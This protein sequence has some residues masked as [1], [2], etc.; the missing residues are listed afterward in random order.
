[1]AQTYLLEGAQGE[2]H[3]IAT[4][5]ASGAGTVDLDLADGNVHHVTLTGNP[6][7][8]FTTALTG[9]ALRFRLYL[10]QDGT[11]S[12]TVTWPGTVDWPGGTAPTLTT[13]ADGVDVIDFETV[14]DGTTWRGVV[15]GQ[16][17]A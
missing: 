1:M 16:A 14:D 13:T 11:G 3:T 10:V 8:T 12:R 4:V 2:R 7:F 9:V 6:T 5:A 17:F 15:W